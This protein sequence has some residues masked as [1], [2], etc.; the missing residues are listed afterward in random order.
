M[1]GFN[2]FKLPRLII[3][4][5]LFFTNALAQNLS[6]DGTN[7]YV[8]LSSPMNFSGGDDVSFSI[9]IK[10][11]T[12]LPASGS[13]ANNETIFRQDSNGN[14]DFYI[15]FTHDG[16]FEF[17][18]KT[19]SAYNELEVNSGNFS[20][21]NSWVHIV[22]TYD[23]SS[24]KL[25]KNGSQIGSASL[26]GNV[27]YNSSHDFGFGYSPHGSGSEFFDGEIDEFSVWN[28]ALSAAEIT[29]L[30]NSGNS[31][32]AAA[33]AGNYT[34]SGNLQGYWKMNEGSGSSLADGSSNSNVGTIT[35]ATLSTSSAPTISSVSSTTSNGSY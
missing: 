32:N 30:Y 11:A 24:Q 35:G 22:A 13:N 6:F 33:N 5:S 10:K 12:A 28:D 7:D 20:D 4:V 9:W 21:W 34:S 2:V 8:E 23:G 15:G 29:A 17:A 27:N 3:C 25:Y 31:L 14:P 18:L 16:K 19:S 1:N 26:S